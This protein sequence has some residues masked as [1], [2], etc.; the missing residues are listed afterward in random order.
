MIEDKFEKVKEDLTRMV[1]ADPNTV[2]ETIDF[3]SAKALAK[4]LKTV[5]EFHENSKKSNITFKK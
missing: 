3:D 5:E 1:E 4:Y 2:F